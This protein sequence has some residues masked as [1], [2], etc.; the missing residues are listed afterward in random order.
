MGVFFLVVSLVERRL[1]CRDV[2]AKWALSDLEVSAVDNCWVGCGF[3]SVQ[4]AEEVG[5]SSDV[6]FSAPYCGY[7]AVTGADP[8]VG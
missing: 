1:G 2:A 6:E 4:Y 3:V 7:V 5:M 8:G